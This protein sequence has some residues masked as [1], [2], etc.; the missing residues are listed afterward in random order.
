MLAASPKEWQEKIHQL[1][2]AKYLTSSMLSNLRNELREEV[3]TD[4]EFSLRK[5]I[6]KFFF[7]F[8]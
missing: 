6:G 8:Y 4:Y 7:S 1:I 5:A 2:P 3:N